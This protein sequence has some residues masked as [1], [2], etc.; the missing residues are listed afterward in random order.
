MEQ[1]YNFFQFPIDCLNEYI[2]SL[3][4]EYYLVLVVKTEDMKLAPVYKDVSVNIYKVDDFRSELFAC[5]HSVYKIEQEEELLYTCKLEF[6][7][8]Y[9]K[10]INKIINSGK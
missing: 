6:K 3:D 4:L 2:K 9:S 5:I 1:I 8:I 10:I 7:K